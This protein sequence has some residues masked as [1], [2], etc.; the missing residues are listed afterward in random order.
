M[1]KDL[2]F[3]RLYSMFRI[4]KDSF[5]EIQVP[6]EALWGAQTQRSLKFFKIGGENERMPIQLIKSIALIK[7]ACAVVNHKKALISK[8]ISGA[9]A[10]ASV[11][12]INGQLDHHFPLSIWQTGSGT[13]TNMN[14][15]EVL[16]S[17]L[18]GNS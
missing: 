4:E 11:E 18:E 12:V 14:V 5:G 13:Q 15:N 16:F 10:K 7:K 2:F 3:K 8:D 1:K 17:F 6:K 9:I